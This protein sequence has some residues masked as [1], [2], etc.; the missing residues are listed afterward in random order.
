LQQANDSWGG[1]GGAVMFAWFFVFRA[2]SLYCL[3]T[4][5]FL[6]RSF[7]LLTQLMLQE[8]YSCWIYFVMD[9]YYS[10]EQTAELMSAQL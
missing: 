7:S 4:Y 3:D 8:E 9:C 1:V 5:S 10:H 2:V 6:K